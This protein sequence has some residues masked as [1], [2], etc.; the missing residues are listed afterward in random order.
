LTERAIRILP[1]GVEKAVL[2]TVVVLVVVVTVVGVG[3]T[4][5]IGEMPQQEHALR[6]ADVFGQT[7]A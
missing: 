7:D 4:I 3:K 6:Y 5:V 1:H 2:V